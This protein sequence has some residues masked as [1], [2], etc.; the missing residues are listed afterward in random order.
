MG[1]WKRGKG[2]LP[3]EIKESFTEEVATELR[4]DQRSGGLC[5]AGKGNDRCTD[6]EAQGALEGAGYAGGARE[7]GRDQVMNL[8]FVQQTFIECILCARH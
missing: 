2:H 5:Q 1:T 8:P 4:L 7:V 3:G 6:T